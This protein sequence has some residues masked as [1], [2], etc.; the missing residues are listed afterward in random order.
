MGISNLKK[1]I[2]GMLI[3]GL[4]SFLF[5]DAVVDKAFDDNQNEFEY[6]WYYYDDNAGIGADDRPQIDPN[7]TPSIIDVEYK[8]KPRAWKGDASDTWKVK[9]YK[10]VTGEHKSKKCAIVPYKL[11]DPWKASYCGSKICAMPYVGIGTMLTKDSSSIDLTGVEN[12]YF[13]VKSAKKTLN[14]VVKVEILSINKLSTDHKIGDTYE[15]GEFGYH[16]FSFTAEPG[17]WTLVEAP[18]SSFKLPTWAKTPLSKKGIKESLTEHLNEATKLAWELKVG[19]EEEAEL[20][21]ED[22]IFIADVYFTGSYTFVS[23]T[24]WNKYENSLPSSPMGAF[25]T[26]EKSPRNASPLGT[27]WYAYND[28]EIGGNSSV[29]PDYATQDEETK[30]LTINFKPGTGSGGTYG[31]AL[32]YELGD[33]VKKNDSITI[34]G[35]VGIGCNLYDSVSATYFDATEKNVNSIYFE[36]FT[37]GDVK[38]VTFELSDINDV[39]DAQNPDRRDSRGSGIVYYRNFLPTT[40]GEWKKV[41]IPFDSLVVHSDWQGYN[42]IP[43]DKKNLAKIQWKVQGPKGMM[44]AFAIDNIC[45]PGWEELGDVGVIRGRRSVTDANKGLYAIVKNGMVNVKWN[46]PLTITSGRISFVNSLGAVV[47]GINISNNNGIAD[48][49]ASN[50]GTGLYFVRLSGKDAAGK[51][52]IMQMPVSIVK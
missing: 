1:A 29:D 10:F 46:T 5:A 22:T 23:P 45:F 41:L 6:Y 38:Y 20:V 18:I 11:G 33:P 13:Y 47:D 14:M 32:M 25:A 30:R 4:T 50:L 31:A 3:A 35:F 16:E 44:G 24:V 26:F 48:F 17:D 9:D 21:K 7:G 8:E 19:D 28:A 12:L 52:V 40:G 42:H 39:G 51:S 37:D 43:L 27:Y 49:K 2:G 36:Y 15:N 34:L